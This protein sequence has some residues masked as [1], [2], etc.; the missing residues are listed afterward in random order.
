[1][2]VGAETI[3]LR[4]IVLQ[5]LVDAGGQISCDDLKKIYRPGM[6][7]GARNSVIIRDGYA[8]W[9]RGPSG[10]AHSIRIT[11]MGRDALS[12]TI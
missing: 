10:N 4:K 12:K 2:S 8:E 1:M 11:E 7:D 9:V 6:R 3:E 5:A